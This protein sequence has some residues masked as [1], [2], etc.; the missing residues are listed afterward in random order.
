MAFLYLKDKKDQQTLK[1]VQQ[2]LADLPAST[3]KL[4]DIVNLK[5]IKLLVL[6]QKQLL[7]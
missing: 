1:Q 4:F 6:T 2:I 5:I 3:K 7:H